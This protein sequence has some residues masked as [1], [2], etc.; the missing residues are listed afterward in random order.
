[1]LKNVLF[2]IFDTWNGCEINGIEEYEYEIRWKKL[3][4]EWG[5]WVWKWMIPSQSV[6]TVFVDGA[7]LQYDQNR[8]NCFSCEEGL[9]FFSQFYCL[10]LVSGWLSNLLSNYLKILTYSQSLPWGQLVHHISSYIVEIHWVIEYLIPL[11]V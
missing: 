8:C 9:V 7:W 10:W 6:W 5:W 11:L 2:I 4:N 1:M 3:W